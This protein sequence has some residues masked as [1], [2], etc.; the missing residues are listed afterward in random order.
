MNKL[1]RGIAATCVVVVGL[2]GCSKGDEAAQSAAGEAS[3]KPIVCR[4]TTTGFG[5]SPQ[6]SMM[7]EEWERI[8][9]EKMGREL[10]IQWEYVSSGDYKEKQKVILAGG[11]IPDI[12][13]LFQLSNTDIMKYGKQQV[14]EELTQH[15]DKLPNYKRLLD[16]DEKAK[17]KLYSEDGKTYAFYNTQS[18]P[19]GQ[20]GIYAAAAVRTD[21][22][23]E[24]GLEI[25]TTLDEVY[26]VAKVL[27]EKYPEKYPIILHEEWQP[28]ENMVYAAN[29][30][31]SG[32]YYNGEKYVYGP[33]EDSYKESLI[34]MNKLYKEGL[35]SP[36]YITHNAEQGTAA[37]ANGDAMMIANIWDGYV[38]NWETQYPEQEWAL[39]PHISK[40]KGDDSWAFTQ[41]D[42]NE[43]AFNTAYSAVVS[44]KSKVKDEMLELLDIQY[45]PEIIELLTWGIR[46]ETFDI[47]E[48]GKNYILDK[49]KVG[50]DKLVE[51]GH[52]S[53]GKSR[54]GIFPQPENYQLKN[55]GFNLPGNIYHEGEIIKQKTYD[56]AVENVN[57]SNVVP[58]Y[59]VTTPTLT[60]DENEQYANTMTA[61]DTYAKEA[62]IKF[63]KGERSFDEWDKY[64]EEINKIGNIEESL[65]IYNATF[66]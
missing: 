12:L 6:G 33:L 18:Y 50:T 2:T 40:E 11:D 55:T 25:P 62:R 41:S 16:I 65:D 14:F 66:K 57:E 30:T 19:D 43:S 5:V 46:G 31:S 20:K 8:C 29:H 17:D 23:K 24:C 48:D 26:N 51:I 38:A 47:G 15:M 9:E 39:I 37:V 3:T 44:S 7:Q 56:F 34:Y 36:D 22:L 45:S 32:R 59:K 27:K 1:V 49:Y 64:I 28:I 10:D 60:P 63:I 42:V 53:S 4:I 13:T 21:I 35:I 54:A 52:P 58:M 61:V